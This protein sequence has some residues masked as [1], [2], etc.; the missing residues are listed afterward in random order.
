VS[1]TATAVVANTPELLSYI[2]IRINSRV[3]TRRCISNGFQPQAAV[4]TQGLPRE[5][6]IGY[7][8]QMPGERSAAIFLRGL[9]DW[10]KQVGH[11]A[12]L[13]QARFVGKGFDREERLCREL[14]LSRYVAFHPTVPRHEVHPLMHQDW[15]LLLIANRQPLQIPGK[16][17]EYLATGRRILCLAEPGSATAALL[18]GVAGCDVVDAPNEVAASLAA[19][20]ST[21]TGSGPS[22]VDRREFLE[23]ASYER[24]A[25]DYA[26]L[27]TEIVRESK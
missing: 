3:V 19:N 15:I 24:R 17:F 16:A 22:T 26:D 23:E 7:Y 10:L 6:R 12:S 1:S 13:V 9:A 21:F 2:S 18:A 14:A 8:G 5:F 25:A 11:D 20:W 4:E 27:L